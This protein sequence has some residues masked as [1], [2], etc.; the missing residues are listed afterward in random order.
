MLHSPPTSRRNHKSQNL[1]ENLRRIEA[2]EFA[3][4]M[5]D[6]TRLRRLTLAIEHL[7]HGSDISK[8]RRRGG[9]SRWES[10]WKASELAVE[11]ELRLSRPL[12][13]ALAGVAAQALEYFDEH[14]TA[15]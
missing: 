5:R 13:T 8:V 11:P 12:W 2:E 3:E 1:Y 10:W 9:L 4:S 14:E 15:A 7:I 6:L